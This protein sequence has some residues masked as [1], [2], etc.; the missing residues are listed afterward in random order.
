MGGAATGRDLLLDEPHCLVWCLGFL[1]APW[2]L[3]CGVFARYAKKTPA[4]RHRTAQRHGGYFLRCRGC[5]LRGVPG[6]VFFTDPGRFASCGSCC[7]NSNRTVC[8]A[9]SRSS[10]VTSVANS[11]SSLLLLARQRGGRPRGL[12]SRS[13]RQIR[14]TR[15]LSEAMFYK[16]RNRVLQICLEDLEPKPRGRRPQLMTDDQAVRGGVGHR[17]RV[18]ERELAAQTVRLELAQ[19]LPQLAKRSGSV[20][21]TKPGALQAAAAACRK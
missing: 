13:S 9:T 17:G 16:L 14:K 21:K 11:A 18:P 20:K 4:L 3:W 8:A 12:G 19:Q 10:V 5:C 2:P 1:L 7:A 6:F 15:F